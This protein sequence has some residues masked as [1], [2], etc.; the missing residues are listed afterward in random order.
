MFNKRQISII[1]GAGTFVDVEALFRT[2]GLVGAVAG[3]M[4][5]FKGKFRAVLIQ[6]PS[7]REKESLI[8]KLNTWEKVHESET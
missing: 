4:F 2:C 5:V 8:L 6:Y 3:S 7:T 1:G